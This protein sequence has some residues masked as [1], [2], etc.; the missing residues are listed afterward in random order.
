M[1]ILALDVGEKRIGIACSDALKL[2]AQGIESYTRVEDEKDIAHI[3]ALIK[4]K[5]V[6]EVVVGMPRNMNGTYGPAAEKAR[7]F[8][9]MLGGRT[10]ANIRFWDERLSTVSAQRTLLE[11]DM[12]R[13]K[14]KKVVDKLAAT[15]ILQ[16][17]LDYLSCQQ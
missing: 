3:V 5:D 1:R 7:A 17:Y 6:H 13:G 4:E 2:T 14:R 9:E 16:G 12:S 15:I 10:D 8:A 11:A